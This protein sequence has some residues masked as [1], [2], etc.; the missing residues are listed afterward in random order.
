MLKIG[1]IF[2]STLLWHQCYCQS[3]VVIRIEPNA[4]YVGA[5]S[6]VLST[7]TNPGSGKVDTIIST[8]CK[9]NSISSFNFVVAG[10]FLNTSLS[11]ARTACENGTSFPNVF[12][13]YANKMLRT[14]KDTLHVIRTN[15]KKEFER[16]Q[17]AGSITKI[18][19]FG[20]NKNKPQLT[21][22]NFFIKTDNEERINIG[23]K[24]TVLNTE[25]NI[26]VIGNFEHIKFVAFLNSTWQEGPVKAI[27]KLI[28][29][30][31]DANNLAVGG[32]IDILEVKASENK[33]LQKKDS[34]E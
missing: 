33:W 34:C 24:T 18:I 29:T 26:W 20:F 22:F 14:L 7:K 4:I 27:N 28:Q 19:F 1:L 17:K 15:S 5:D 6:R 12:T 9:I 25:T 31:A 30:E 32:P 10:G 13:N 2:I 8:T 16:I 3:T 11:V 21:L 23:I